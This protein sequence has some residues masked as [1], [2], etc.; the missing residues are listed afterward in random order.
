MLQSATQEGPR[1]TMS[2]QVSRIGEFELDCRSYMA[3]PLFSP[4]G[5]RAWIRT[6]NPRPVFPETIEFQRDTVFREGSGADEAVWTIV[7]V[8]R[9]AHRAEYVRVAGSHAAHIAVRVDSSGENRCRV[10]VD[11][12]VTAFGENAEGL[13]EGFS[14]AAYAAKMRNWQRQIEEYLQSK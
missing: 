7:D 13:L 2:Q 12:T 1:L 9:G 10:V 8:D 6:W 4:E 3:F 5:E 11:Y 14:E